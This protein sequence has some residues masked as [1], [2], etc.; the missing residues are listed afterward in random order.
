MTSA[1]R[2][3]VTTTLGVRGYSDALST[4][5]GAKVN[6]SGTIGPDGALGFLMRVRRYI[7]VQADA[8]I[9]H[10]LSSGC[11]LVLP[12][13]DT[14]Y[15]ARF[16]RD[17][18]STSAVR[19]GAET[20]AS[21]PLLRFTAGVGALWG[22]PTTPYGVLGAAFSTRGRKRFL[23]EAERLQLRMHADEVHHAVAGGQPYSKS[24]TLYPASFTIRIGMEWAFGWVGTPAMSP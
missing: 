3:G 9:G 14:S 8:S 18:F 1:P 12:N 20:P 16:S 11:F 5:C 17:P 22:R 10:P 23:M 24:L 13:T 21:M 4:Q 7:V 15:D 2:F 19:I 6:G